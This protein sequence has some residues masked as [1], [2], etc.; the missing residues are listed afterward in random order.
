[1]STSS[2]SAFPSIQH[3]I[4]ASDKLSRWSKVSLVDTSPCRA[5]YQPT[6]FGLFKNLRYR[7]AQSPFVLDVSCGPFCS[8]DLMNSSALKG[9]TFGGAR[10]GEIV[11]AS[12]IRL[13]K[14]LSSGIKN[15]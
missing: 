11:R 4:L 3:S 1:M 13:A 10:Y 9:F 14:Y 5:L 8:R 7:L 12:G 2:T 15:V 6:K